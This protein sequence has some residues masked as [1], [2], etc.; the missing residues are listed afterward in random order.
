MFFLWFGDLA[1]TFGGWLPLFS[2]DVAHLAMAGGSC[3]P[4]GL[5]PVSPGG[6]PE[7]PRTGRARGV[8]SLCARAVG[9]GKRSAHPPL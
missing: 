7:I 1:L 8:A 2:V 6:L 5:T 9:G 3:T 4:T